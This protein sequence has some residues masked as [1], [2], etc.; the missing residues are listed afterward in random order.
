MIK[1]ISILFI[2]VS[3]VLT[4]CASS[5]V[6][7]NLA[8]PSASL[9][10]ST[11]DSNDQ[12]TQVLISRGHSFGKVNEKLYGVLEKPEEVHAF[13]EAIK[14]A[15]KI[16]GILDIREPDY[17]VVINQN[18]THQSIHLW[19]EQNIASGMFTYISDTGTG[20]NLT[21]ESTTQLLN[22]IQKTRYEPERAEENGDV[23]L[24]LQGILNPNR[25]KTFLHNVEKGQA[26]S[27]QVTAY[28][29]EGAPIFYNL[30]FDGE[31][32]RYQ[33]DNT[34]D[35]YGNPVKQVDFCQG[36]DSER[37]EQGTS[38]KLTGCGENNS[39]NSDTFSLVIP[40]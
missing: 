24:S 27:I 31:Q 36:I 4:G 10:S 33:F 20:Y 22:L 5:G 9:K 15:T 25:W 2:A 6:K 38:Y 35:N 19:L 23:V 29:I 30:D 14:T 28:T 3:L 1:K 13:V 34:H 8:S 21:K 37:I 11:V 39:K 18:G 7:G 32:I 17:D 12:A 16:Q 26:G 40:D